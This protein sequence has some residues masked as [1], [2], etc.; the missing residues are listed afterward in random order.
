MILLGL[1]M[2]PCGNPKK[3]PFDFDLSFLEKRFLAYF[4]WNT[5]PSSIKG[6]KKRNCS[7]IGAFRFLGVNA[8]RAN[9]RA[10][11]H[12][13]DREQTMIWGASAAGGLK[14][15]FQTTHTVLYK[16]KP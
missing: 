7:K 8:I 12:K 16:L 6:S 1:N 5:I 14:T 4:A 13:Q 11:Q 3:I 10:L 15:F 9:Y 2:K